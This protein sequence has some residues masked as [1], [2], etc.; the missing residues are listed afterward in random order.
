M[1]GNVWE[2]CYDISGGSYR[3]IR[4]GAYSLN[5]YNMRLGN[6]NFINPF[7]EFYNIGFRFCRTK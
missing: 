6:V 7:S 1:S 2:W 4:G 3:V 5:A